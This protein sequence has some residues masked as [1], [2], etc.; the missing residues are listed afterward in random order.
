MYITLD[1]LRMCFYLI[2]RTYS[3][4]LP[5]SPDALASYATN[6]EATLRTAGTDIRAAIMH[7][8]VCLAFAVTSNRLLTIHRNKGN[9]CL[10]RGS[11]RTPTILA[12]YCRILRY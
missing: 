2:Y 7:T 11:V 8:G 4:P 10:Q 12:L 6:V 3:S 1:I 9:A 5:I